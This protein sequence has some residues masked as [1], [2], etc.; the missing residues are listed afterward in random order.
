MGY[1]TSVIVI[2]DA[3]NDIKNDPEFGKNMVK[4]IQKL[5]LPSEYRHRSE[6]DVN[7]RGHCNAASVIETHHADQTALVAVGGNY[8]NCLG[9]TWGYSH[10][11]KDTQL[12]ILKQI[13]EQFGYTL[14]KKPEK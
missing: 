3:L 11:A 5:S 1:N 8:G 13:A 7:A 6:L 2:N 12:E 9:M 14:H 10:H 4:A